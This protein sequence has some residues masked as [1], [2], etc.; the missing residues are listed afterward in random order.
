MKNNNKYTAG[1]LNDF[2]IFC[3]I[4]AQPCWY[5]ESIKLGVYTGRGGA[6][7]CRKD[8]D[9]IDYGLVPYKIPAEKPIPEARVNN[10][11]NSTN[12]TE[13]YS[14]IQ[15]YEIQNPLSYIPTP[16]TSGSI[17]VWENINYVT[18]DAWTTPWGG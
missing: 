1:R 12:I 11:N 5:S 8:A 9:A 10:F 15:D 14:P 3:D 16:S 6:R 17:L 13:T 4:C 2:I 18:W 7:V